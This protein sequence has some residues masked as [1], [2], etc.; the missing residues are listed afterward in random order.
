V[1]LIKELTLLPVAPLR[2]TV[3]VAEKVSEE[4]DRQ[5]FSTGAGIRKLEEIEQARERGE[6]DEREAQEREAA[7]LQEQMSQTPPAEP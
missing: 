1:G 5:E 3:W 4:V 2:F 7:V 6:L